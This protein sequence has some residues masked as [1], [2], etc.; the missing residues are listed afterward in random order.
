MAGGER[1][2]PRSERTERDTTVGSRMERPGEEMM[3]IIQ[4][5]DPLLKA[6]AWL[7]FINTLDA[8]Q[9]ESVV[10]ELRGAGLQQSNMSEYGMLLTAWAKVDPLAALDY[11]SENTGS[12][13]ARNTILAAWAATDPEAAIM[14]AGANHDG[15]GANPWMV[16]VING[17]AAYDPV[18]ATELMNDLPYSRERG[19]ALGAIM[20]QIL[21][22]GADAAKDWVNSLADE[23]LRDGAIGR[24]A[25][26]L[27]RQDPE[28]TAQ[29]L[30][31][32]PGEA[33]RR[34]MDDVLSTWA[35]SDVDAA[36]SYYYDLPQGDL[37]TS[38]LRGLTNQMATNDPQ[39][40]AA[41]LDANAAD[42]DDRVY[43]QFAWHS[44]REDPSLAANYIGRIQDVEERDSTYRR[45]LD[46][47]LRRDFDAASAWIGSAQLPE[48]VSN[49]LNRRIE[50]QQ[51]RQN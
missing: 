30:A 27:A 33:A 15:D 46:G 10:A 20:P 35:R 3:R 50:E 47:W 4:G 13:F 2:R 23:R 29:W 22:Q 12:P 5:K 51:Q 32:N 48:D 9:F 49:H 17:L 18:R 6:Q 39:A 42:A 28:G 24:L 37:R 44:F 16:G 19:E 1:T 40:A 36:T 14:W 21:A 7:D 26:E 43:Q 38:A 11:A 34:S 45:M 8:D 25:D 41:F 31:S